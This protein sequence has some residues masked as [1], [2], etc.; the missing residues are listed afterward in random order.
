MVAIR[1]LTVE[2]AARAFPGRR[3]QDVAEYLAALRQVEPGESAEVALNGLSSRALKRRLGQAA[4]QL[5]VHLKWARAASPTGLYFQVTPQRTATGPGPRR[6]ASTTRRTQGGAPNRVEA[7]A[8]G[9]APVAYCMKCR[10]PREM[11]NP[12]PITMKNGRPATEG[13]CPTC[14]TRLFKIGKAR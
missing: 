4:A 6:P 1:K 14:G 10:A 7:A 2:E 13:E 5:G 9:A 3:E 11:R 12:R 8:V